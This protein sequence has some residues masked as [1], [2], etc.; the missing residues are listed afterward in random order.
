MSLGVEDCPYQVKCARAACVC[1]GLEETKPSWP[2][3]CSHSLTCLC[4]W[5]VIPPAFLD[6]LILLHSLMSKTAVRQDEASP[7]VVLSQTPPRLVFAHLKNG[8][9]TVPTTKAWDGSSK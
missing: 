5:H 8:T 7:P 6:L 3:P 2:A 1:Y 4:G 9:N